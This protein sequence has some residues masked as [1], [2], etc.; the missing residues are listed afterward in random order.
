[1]M[2]SELEDFSTNYRGGGKPSSFFRKVILKTLKEMEISPLWKYFTVAF[3]MLLASLGCIF[4][5]QTSRKRID[6]VLAGW[7]V[8]T[9]F[10]RFLVIDFSSYSSLAWTIANV[11]LAIGLVYGR[12]W[13]NK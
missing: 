13:L 5:S 8:I 11:T 7:L 10:S 3:T 4:S 2:V 12:E 9:S 1:M 6:M